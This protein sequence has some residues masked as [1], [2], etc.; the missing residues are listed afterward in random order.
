MYTLP[1]VVEYLKSNC[2]S[3]RLVSYFSPEPDPPVAHASRPTGALTVDTH[4][5]S[6]DARLTLA[7][8]PRG[9]KINLAGLLATLPADLIEEQIGMGGLPST[10]AGGAL[11]IPPL[12][13]LFGT[14]L[15]VDEAVTLAAVICFEA[16]A[17]TDFIEMNYDDFARLEQPRVAPVALAGE[18]PAA[19]I[20]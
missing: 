19:L 11:L 17:T 16:F 6:I 7:C 5:L 14:P 15:L 20:H 12:G 8:V 1:H 13:R 3:F 18:L 2:V 9:E 4:V 10:P